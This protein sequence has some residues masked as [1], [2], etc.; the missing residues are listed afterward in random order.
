MAL[1]IRCRSGIGRPV[2]SS[3]LKVAL[4]AGIAVFFVAAFLWL[5]NRGPGGDVGTVRRL[6]DG[7][8]LELRQVIFANGY[9]YKHQTGNR[10]VRLVAPVTPAFIK[11]RF[12]PPSFSGSFGF[13]GDGNTNLILVTVNRSKAPNWWSS[14]ARLRVFDEQGNVYDARWGSHTLGY[15]GEIVHGWQVRAFPRRSR[16]VGLLFLAQNPDGSWTNVSSFT[17]RNPAG[18]DYPQWT[19]EPWPSTKSAGDLAVTLREFQS[20]GR[21]SGDRG[22]GDE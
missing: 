16:T 18:A 7:S 21:M 15:T 1:V 13:G 17:I 6:P 11:N 9:Q 12:F 5:V 14:L 4:F 2:V 20:G 10:F 22:Q 8:T 3:K 19:P